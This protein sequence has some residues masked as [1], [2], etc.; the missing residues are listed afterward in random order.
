[1]RSRYEA[2]EEQNF[3]ESFSDVALCTLTV[4]LVL[5]AL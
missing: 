4:T 5:A 2:D 3:F 1:M